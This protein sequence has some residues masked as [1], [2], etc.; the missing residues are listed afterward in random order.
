VTYVD[1]I[2]KGTIDE[3]ILAALRVKKSLADLIVSSN[4]RSFFN[5]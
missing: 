5:E 2:A 4:W 1:L 3:K